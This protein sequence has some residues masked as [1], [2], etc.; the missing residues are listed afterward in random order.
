MCIRDRSF[1]GGGRG[2]RRGADR[3]REERP[4]AESEKSPRWDEPAETTSSRGES[5]GFREDF[6]EDFPVDRTTTRGSASSRMSSGS[7]FWVF[8]EEPTD[9]GTSSASVAAADASFV[10]F[11]STSTRRAPPRDDFVSK[12]D[13]AVASRAAASLDAF[14]SRL[15]VLVAAPRAGA[16][17][18]E[19]P[20]AANEKSADGFGAPGG[21]GSDAGADGFGAAASAAAFAAAVSAASAAARSLGDERTGDLRTGDFPG[22]AAT[23]E[24][25]AMGAECVRKTGDADV[26]GV[27][28]FVAAAVSAAVAEGG[29]AVSFS[30]SFSFFFLPEASDAI[31]VAPRGAASASPRGGFSSRRRAFASPSGVRAA[32]SRRARAARSSPTSAAAARA[33]ASEARSLWRSATGVVRFSVAALSNHASTFSSSVDASGAWKSK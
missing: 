19:A 17:R 29:A 8:C 3:A 25:P 12:N 2:A 28:S 6:T 18:A 1:G 7:V 33:T 22:A 23:G 14:P 15:G 30:F 27:A 32:S 4:V 13:V 9:I 24:R 31:G 20:T 11:V 21:S 26:G 16:R 5:P 10:S